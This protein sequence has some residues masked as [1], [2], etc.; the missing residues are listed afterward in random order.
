MKNVT[1]ERSQSMLGKTNNRGGFQLTRLKRSL[2][3]LVVAVAIA[4]VGVGT[5]AADG[6]VSTG[7]PAATTN[8]AQLG[9]GY[10]EFMFDF[11]ESASPERMSYFRY[12]IDGQTVDDTPWF[13]FS[14][15]SYWYY[16]AG[17]QSTGVWGLWTIAATGV[18]TIEG[19]EYRHYLNG[20]N[21]WVYLGSCT[22]ASFGG[23]TNGWNFN[24]GVLPSP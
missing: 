11:P 23:D 16:D 18:H 7:Y 4:I 3:S 6:V 9:C 2:V 1:D 20:Y 5:A 19:W 22:T 12:R 24:V 14:G 21:S 17:W 15:N 8:D 13:Y 10:D